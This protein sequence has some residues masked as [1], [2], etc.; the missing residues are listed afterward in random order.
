MNSCR[1]MWCGLYRHCFDADT[2]TSL[3]VELYAAMCA[4]F[5]SALQMF[6]KQVPLALVYY[7]LRECFQTK[8]KAFF[9]S[10]LLHDFYVHYF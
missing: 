2:N 1:E 10:F 9:R 7:C 4:L 5:S 8:L 6:T 3:A